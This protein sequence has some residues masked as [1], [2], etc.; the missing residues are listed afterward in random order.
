M[1]YFAFR[2]VRIKRSF[3]IGFIVCG[4]SFAVASVI[5]CV[6]AGFL[7]QSLCSDAAQ[8]IK[9]SSCNFSFGFIFSHIKMP[10]MMIFS[11]LFL[12]GFVTTALVSSVKGFA[13]SFTV[14]VLLR[15]TANVSVLG[16]LKLFA[17]DIFL[18]IPFLLLTGAAAFSLSSELYKSVIFG[19]GEFSPRATVLLGLVDCVFAALQAIVVYKILPNLF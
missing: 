16:L 8:Q 14:G 2:N 3:F 17:V 7:P 9:A 1:S 4:V 6:C 5:G 12:F 11:G 18:S 15:A 10:V 19:K 13:F